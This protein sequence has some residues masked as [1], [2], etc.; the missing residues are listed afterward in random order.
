MH[1]KNSG[2]N[3]ESAQLSKYNTEREKYRTESSH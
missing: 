1:I 3:W 2:T